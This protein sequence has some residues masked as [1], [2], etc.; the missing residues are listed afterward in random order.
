MKK[1]LLLFILIIPFIIKAQETAFFVHAH[2]DDAVYF[3]SIPLFEKVSTGV[4]TVA[5]VISASDQ[6]AHDGIY[7]PDVGIGMT[8]PFY[9]ARD[10]GYKKALEYCYTDTNVPLNFNES[11]SD[12]IFA[13]KKVRKW[14][15]GSGITMY[16]LD[17]PN[18]DCC[19]LDQEGYP[20]NN[21]QSIEKLKKGK[22]STI[23][24][25]TGTTSYTWQ[26]LK[27][28]I[29]EIFN[30]EK[31]TVSNV[32]SADVNLNNNPNDHAD[33]YISSV[34][35]LE[36][37]DGIAGFHS[38]Q[39]I[40][41]ALM[42]KV[43]NLSDR[44]KINKI[45]TFGAMISGIASKGYRANRHSSPEYTKWFT[46]EYIRDANAHDDLV[47]LDSKLGG[48]PN[49]AL[50]KTTQVSGSEFNT[51]GAKANDG[52]LDTY[53]GNTPNPQWWKVDLGDNYNVTDITVINYNKD[54][55]SY[56]YKV[57]A[58][59]NNVNWNK[60]CEKS[61][62]SIA[63]VSGNKFPFSNPV[64]ARYLKVELTYNS[65]NQGVHIAEFIAHGKLVG[66]DKNTAGMLENV[67]ESTEKLGIYTNPVKKGES[68]TIN[69]GK[70]KNNKVSIY[71]LN[72][73]P[74]FIQK[75]NDQF[76]NINTSFIILSG[77]YIIE[78]N[79][80]KNKLIIE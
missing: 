71:D 43:A 24:N 23:T 8:T 78:I 3:S 69:F 66:N 10:N 38:K 56:K 35:A 75:F 45:S 9:Q 22:I 52:N 53:W 58:S 57:Y 13:G 74:I 27:N 70:Q 36:A 62:D 25:V 42:N 20:A 77:I 29:K 32:Y 4:K 44:E 6:G 67:S 60:V 59:K 65:A 72:G 17:L 55:R 46:S 37:M 48:K 41:Y 40:D 34:L 61:D 11:T 49:I 5:I 1:N 12:V 54:S 68:L 19:S 21:F 26:E 63:T 30:A 7:T 16:F 31:G 73:K 2:Q 64:T 39:H 33:H 80:N 76:A 28:T 79:D 18:G 50:N 15:Y 51:N 14:T 47:N